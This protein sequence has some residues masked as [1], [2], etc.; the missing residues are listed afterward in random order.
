LLFSGAASAAPI[1]RVPSEEAVPW[2]RC[3]I[4]DRA[5][6][7]HFAIVGD[8]TGGH[9]PGVF[10]EAVEKLN[11]MQPAFVMSVGDLIEGGTENLQQLNSEWDEFDALVNALEMPF[12]YVAGNHD[13]AQGA[14]D[15]VWLARR[16]QSYYAFVHHNVLFLCLNT[17]DM[18]DDQ[19]AYLKRVLE[20]TLP[21][22]WIFVF[23]HRPIWDDARWLAFE[24]MLTGLPYTVFSGHGH[25]Y[26][27]NVRNGRHY[28][29]LAT[30]GGGSDLSGAQHGKMDHFVWVTMTAKGPR[31]GNLLLDGVLGES[32]PE[33]RPRQKVMTSN[34][35]QETIEKAMSP[36]SRP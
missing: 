16:G 17:E 31:I 3:W 36:A 30:T 35:D 10:A 23:L 34:G 29:S 1:A 20:V 19:N 25:T 18:G 13:Y 15:K 8:R 21:V 9:R 2:T 27:L 28:I 11:L 12:F 24:A 14:M 22:R 33:P 32:M 26:A 5:D 4:Y 6:R 7:F